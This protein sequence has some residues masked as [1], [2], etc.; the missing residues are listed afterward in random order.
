MDATPGG[1]GDRLM[2]P[3]CQEMVDGSCKSTWTIEGR[4]ESLNF[5]YV[6]NLEHLVVTFLLKYANGMALMRAKHL[7]ANAVKRYN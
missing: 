6:A 5:S 3:R 4:R 1:L 2:V 7:Q